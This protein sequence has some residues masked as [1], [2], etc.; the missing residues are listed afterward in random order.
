[1]GPRL[2]IVENEGLYRDML[3]SSLGHYPNLDV[4][5]C[6][7]DGA[8]AIQLAREQQANVVLLDIEL[9]GELN[10]I[11]VGKQ[12]KNDNPG[13]GIV[14][15]SSHNDGRYIDAI[16]L[17]EA[18]GWSYLTKQSVTD[19]SVLIRA[20][21]ESAAG[22]NVMDPGVVRDTVFR[23]SKLLG[24]LSSRQLNILGLIAVGYDDT[25]IAKELLLREKSVGNY[26]NTLYQQL[27]ISR[28]DEIHPR[29]MATLIF[30]R[31]SEGCQEL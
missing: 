14:L 18:S 21:A 24:S 17:G 3:R 13:T 15:L 1:M 23:S 10:G 11:E 19:L 30:L 12:I 29:V 2:L 7:A 25:E 26:I 31:E 6:V 16:P 27:Q 8:S 20:I 22:L 28:Q 4:V 9:G 5:G